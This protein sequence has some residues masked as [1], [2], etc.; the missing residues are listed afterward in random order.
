MNNWIDTIDGGSA[1]NRSVRKLALAFG[2][3]P[4]RLVVRTVELF[5]TWQIRSLERQQLRSLSDHTLKD[6][7]LSRADTVREADKPFWRG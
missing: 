5:L 6:I 1:L 2:T 7:G 3:A 4:G